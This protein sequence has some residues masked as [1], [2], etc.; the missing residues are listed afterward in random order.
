MSTIDV[1]MTGDDDDPV[2]AE[3]EVC[4]NGSLKD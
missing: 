2:V 4:L 1:A 3:F